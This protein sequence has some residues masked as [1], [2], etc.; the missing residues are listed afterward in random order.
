MR[1]Q[2]LQTQWLPILALKALRT[3]IHLQSHLLGQENRTNQR[4]LPSSNS[5]GPLSP[6]ATATSTREDQCVRFLG[7]ICALHNRQLRPYLVILHPLLKQENTREKQNEPKEKTSGHRVRFAGKSHFFQSFSSTKNLCSP[8][9][10]EHRMPWLA[11]DRDTGH[12][13]LLGSLSMYLIAA[14]FQRTE[15]GE[16]SWYSGVNS[17]IAGAV[18]VY[19]TIIPSYGYMLGI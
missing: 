18:R 12:L 10:G 5:K 2:G 1:F 17:M 3:V 19:I 9:F 8:F 16:G 6:S 15:Q 13:Q 4:D 11:S 14:T 7:T